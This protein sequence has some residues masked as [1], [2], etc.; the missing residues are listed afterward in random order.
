MKEY[1]EL[2]GEDEQET[3]KL[4]N[5]PQTKEI[6]PRC[7]SPNKRKV[8]CIQCWEEIRRKKHQGFCKECGVKTRGRYR[9]CPSCREN[10]YD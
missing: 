8:C 7:N 5:I 6:C 9:L 2:F 1:D 3:F 10:R 4:D